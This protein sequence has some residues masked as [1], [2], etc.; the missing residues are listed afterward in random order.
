MSKTCK[1]YNYVIS[2]SC[3]AAILAAAPVSAMVGL[4]VVAMVALLGNIPVPVCD[5]QLLV[6]EAALLW[7]F[8]LPLSIG[9]A[10]NLS[11]KDGY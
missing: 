8:P 5:F 10:N 6:A 11:G 2:T 4:A 9:C 7:S 3:A 1:V